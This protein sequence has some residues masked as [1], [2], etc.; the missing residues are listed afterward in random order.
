MREGRT[1]EVHRIFDVIRPEFSRHFVTSLTAAVRRP[2][3]P[4]GHCEY[5]DAWVIE[6][7]Y[8][9]KDG[10]PC[11]STGPVSSSSDF[12]LLQVAKETLCNRI[13]MAV[14]PTTHAAGYVQ[15]LE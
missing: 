4:V 5:A 10:Q 12:L 9:F 2:S 1:E 8:V 6:Q 3:A 7:L 14:A 11:V 15:R 13:I